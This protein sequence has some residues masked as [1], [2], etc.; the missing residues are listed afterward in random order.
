[1][2][3]MQAGRLRHR[4]T[5]QEERPTRDSYKAEVLGWVD[6]ATVWAAV[7]PLRGREYFSAQQVNSEVSH[8]VTIRYR[9]GV[10]SAM[11]VLF[12][13]RVLQIDGVINV[14]E[15]NRELQL[16]CIEG[17]SPDAGQDAS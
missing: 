6:V 4:I 15:Q 10:T 8:R 1:V 13:S 2:I 14:N 5:L 3:I 9:S 16:M 17:V 11:R 7:E 12:G